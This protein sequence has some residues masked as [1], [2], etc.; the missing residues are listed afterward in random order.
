MIRGVIFD[1]DGVITDTAVYHYQSWRRI[2]TEVNFDLTEEHN[3]QLKGVS[4]AE[5]LDRILG[6]ANALRTEEEKAK[7]LVQKNEHYLTLIESLNDKDILPGIVAF[8]ENIRSAGIKTAV[9]S[10]SKNAHFILNKLRL[11]DSFDA[12]V[13]GNMVKQT[14]P[15]PEVFILAAQLLGLQQQECIVVED[16]E[17]GV[18]AAKAAGMKVLGITAHGQLHQADLCTHNLL[19]KDA[20]F[21]QQF[22][23]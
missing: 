12:V 23:S 10:S 21:I 20:Q 19:E 18:L 9:G 22:F 17:A 3:E 13:D 5:S 6:W 14:K 15:D 8:L 16:A 1:L 7:L 11:I 2:A 4:R